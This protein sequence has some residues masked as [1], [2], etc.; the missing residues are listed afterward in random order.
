MNVVGLD[1]ADV[2]TLVSRRGDAE[3][4]SV[5]ATIIG[6]EARRVA[7]P[8]VI[9]TLLDADDKPVYQWSVVTRARDLEPGEV[10]G[11]ATE[12]NAPPSGVARVR[13]SF[14]D[15]AASSDVPVTPTKIPEEAAH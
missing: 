4:L 13:L 10:I 15:G 7:V 8:A 5:N 14:A 6:V 2:S 12:L 11:L 9:V 1:F 3:V